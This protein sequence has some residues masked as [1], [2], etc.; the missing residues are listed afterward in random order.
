MTLPIKHTNPTL[1]CDPL[2]L[3]RLLL[4]PTTNSVQVCTALNKS[5]LTRLVL[6]INL[7]LVKLYHLFNTLV[8]QMTGKEYKLDP[9]SAQ[10]TMTR[11]VDTLLRCLAKFHLQV[12]SSMLKSSEVQSLRTARKATTTPVALARINT[13]NLIPVVTTSSSTPLR[14]SRNK[15]H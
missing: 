14:P 10:A 12:E 11:M 4:A 8:G 5:M 7:Q 3:N 13:S 1:E 2:S 9:L 6:P 15:A